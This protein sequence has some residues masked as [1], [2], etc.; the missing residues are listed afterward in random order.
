MTFERRGLFFRQQDSFTDDVVVDCRVL[1]KRAHFITSA[2]PVN[3]FMTKQDFELAFAFVVC[4]LV[5]VRQFDVLF[6]SGGCCCVQVMQSAFGHK[7]QHFVK[8]MGLELRLHLVEILD[9]DVVERSCELRLESFQL[10]VGGQLRCVQG[11]R[12]RS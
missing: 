8:L 7:I 4:D 3:L 9:N 2:E 5:E 11:L 12:F 6:D 10:F 1:V